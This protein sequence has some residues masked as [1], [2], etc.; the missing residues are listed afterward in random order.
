M[1]TVITFSVREP[2]FQKVERHRFVI[3]PLSE[4]NPGTP[5][6]EH[7]MCVKDVLENDAWVRCREP[8]N[9]I[10]LGLILDAMTKLNKVVDKTDT[11]FYALGELA[12]PDFRED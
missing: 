9:G 11:S 7:E 5:F 1:K 4:K 2:I 10:W 3:V 6:A 8:L 12:L